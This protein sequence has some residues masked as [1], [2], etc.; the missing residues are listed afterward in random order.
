[1]TRYLADMTTC[2]YTHLIETRCRNT[3]C[4]NSRASDLGE[5]AY[6]PECGTKLAE[7]RIKLG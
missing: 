7:H 5:W 6:C 3:E 2:R 1:M 4:S